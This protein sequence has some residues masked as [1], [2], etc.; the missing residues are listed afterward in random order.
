RCAPRPRSA[1]TSATTQK[2]PVTPCPA[3]ATTPAL[4]AA[5]RP[6]R[7]SSRQFRRGQQGNR[8]GRS[9]ASRR[10]R[11]GHIPRNAGGCARGAGREI[12]RHYSEAYEAMISEASPA[13]SAILERDG[14]F[15]LVLRRNPPSADM[16]AFPG[17]R[18]EPGEMPEE[19]ALREF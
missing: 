15:L 7:R 8:S 2:A 17:G 9:R 19:T 11:K 6:R 1:Q 13:S 12:R 14:R 4:P 5:A 16:Y 18:G 10:N 3:P